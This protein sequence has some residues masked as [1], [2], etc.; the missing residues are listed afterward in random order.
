VDGVSG[1]PERLG[2]RV[3]AGRESLRV[4]EQQYFSHVG[5]LRR[6]AAQVTPRDRVWTGAL[7]SPGGRPRTH[8]KHLVRWAGVVFGGRLE[9]AIPHSV[10]R[11]RGTTVECFFAEVHAPLSALVPVDPQRVG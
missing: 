3:H 5:P 2:E 8:A 7:T 10:H 1:A 4:V 9:L 6:R 11:M